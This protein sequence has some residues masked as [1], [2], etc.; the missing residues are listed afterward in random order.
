MDPQIIIDF[1]ES[2]SIDL[3]RYGGKISPPLLSRLGDIKMS[4][5]GLLDMRF[6]DILYS[7]IKILST[8]VDS[9][10]LPS[11]Y[12]AIALDSKVHYMEI[13]LANGLCDDSTIILY[14]DLNR[15]LLDMNLKIHPPYYIHF[16]E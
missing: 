3:N 4:E 16:L 7:F 15:F 8:S 10:R 9:S 5:Y 14:Y 1:L 11:V 2:K 12:D 13:L 6:I